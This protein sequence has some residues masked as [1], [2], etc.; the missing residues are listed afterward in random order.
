MEH[1]LVGVPHFF[2]SHPLVISC[3]KIESMDI[4]CC[5]KHEPLDRRLRP[6]PCC[7]RERFESTERGREFLK[8]IEPG[9]QKQLHAE[10]LGLQGVGFLQGS[11]H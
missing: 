9:I 1:V 4:L 11:P 10:W 7:S 6:W 8:A 3:S 2:E 5:P